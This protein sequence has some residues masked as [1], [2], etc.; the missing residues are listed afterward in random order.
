MTGGG[1]PPAKPRPRILDPAIVAARSR[2][3]EDRFKL[4]FEKRGFEWGTWSKKEKT[5]RR[6]PECHLMLE[7]KDIALLE[8]KRVESGGA[9]RRLDGVIDPEQMLLTDLCSDFLDGNVRSWQGIPPTVPSQLDDARNKYRATVSERPEFSGFPYLIA[10]ERNQFVSLGLVDRRMPAHREISGLVFLVEDRLRYEALA[11]LPLDE[12]ERQ[13]E[14]GDD[15]GVPPPGAV[16]LRLLPNPCARVPVPSAIRDRCELIGYPN[17]LDWP[18]CLPE[19]AEAAALAQLG[20]LTQG[21]REVLKLVYWIYGD[22]DAS[23]KVWEPA[24]RVLLELERLA[25][26]QEGAGSRKRMTR[27]GLALALAA[28]WS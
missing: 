9:G 6:R 8:V 1:G 22:I 11:A 7:N 18:D 28:G 10:F 19:A 25:L 21:Q 24:A 15:S 16:E 12:L 17:D 14:T 5:R 2:A 4:E 3:A 20:E 13:I 26:I 27:L 23:D